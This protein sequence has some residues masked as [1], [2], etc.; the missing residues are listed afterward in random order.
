MRYQ[1]KKAHRA[2]RR[3]REVYRYF[4]PSN[5]AALN[6]TWLPFGNESNSAASLSASTPAFATEASTSAKVIHQTSSRHSSNTTLTSFAQL[7]ALGLNAERCLITIIDRETQY[8]LAEATR[9]IDVSDTSSFISPGDGLWLGTSTVKEAWSLC[10]ETIA[11]ETDDLSQRYPSFVVNNLKEDARFDSLPFVQ[12][13]P[14]FRFYA[15]TPL[16]TENGINIGCLFILDPVP[17][18]GISEVEKR[19]LGT[20]ASL[21]MDFL[22]VSRQASEGRR[23]SRLSRGLRHYVEGS[24]TFI[25]N[26]ESSTHTSLQSSSSR[27]VRFRSTSN[28]SSSKSSTKRSSRSGTGDTQSHEVPSDGRAPMTSSDAS[29]HVSDDDEEI[30]NAPPSNQKNSQQGNRWAFQRAANL[31][32]ESL[33]LRKGGGV[34]F[35][36]LGSN[37]II[38][39]ETGAFFSIETNIP[40]PLLA[41]STEDEPFEVS[42]GPKSLPAASDVDSAFLQQI[43]HRYPRGRLWSF[44]R[45]GTLTSSDEERLTGGSASEASDSGLKD[46]R[47]RTK[48]TET[49]M[50]NAFFP[51]A[52]QIMFVPLWDAAASQWHSGCFCWN[53]DETD[54]FSPAVDLN[55]VMGFASSVMTEVNRVDS[56]RADRRKGDFIGSVSH[57]LRSPLH[58]ILAAAEFL[59]DTC[60][61]GFQSSLIET[62]RSCGQT[63]LDT[64]NQVLDFTKI[65]SSDRKQKRLSRIAQD[66]SEPS[67]RR[68]SRLDPLVITDVSQLLEEVIESVCRGHSF[69]KKSAAKIDQTMRV[70]T[71]SSS[72]SGHSDKDPTD[73][74]EDVQVIIDIKNGDWMYLTQPGSLRRA[75]M[76]ILGN[77][78]KYT[79]HGKIV[80]RLEVD[81]QRLDIPRRQGLEDEV[82]ITVSDTGKGISKSF[83]REKLFKPFNQEDPLAVGTGLGLSI[84]RSLVRN[85]NGRIG[86]ESRPSEGTT[87]TLM[88]PLARLVGKDTSSVTPHSIP[89]SSELDLHGLRRLRHSHAHKRFAIWGLET[90]AMGQ[91]DIF[92]AAIREYMTMWFSMQLVPLSPNEEVDLILVKQ[93]NTSRIARQ[94]SPGYRGLVL[95]FCNDPAE[96]R[97]NENEVSEITY[98]LAFVWLPCGPR[99]LARAIL[100]ILDSSSEEDN[101]HS[102]TQGPSLAKIAPALSPNIQANF[103]Q[104]PD[105]GVLNPEKDAMHRTTESSLANGPAPFQTT[106]DT[107]SAIRPFPAAEAS[108]SDID[109]SQ[110]HQCAPR[111]LVVEDN[112]INLKLILT[113]LK[114]RDYHVLDA[115]TNGKM[116][117]N[118]AEN[119][120]IGYD[121]IFMDMSMPIMDGFEATRTIRCIEREKDGGKAA[122]IVAFTGLSSFEDE[123]KA[124]A[125]GVDMFLSKPVSFRDVAR[126]LD[127]WEIKRKDSSK[128]VRTAS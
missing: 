72:F 108:A 113:F 96:F 116:A 86:I 61:S 46:T 93:Y 103:T 80:V 2:D 57:E 115:A 17:R 45:D 124:F 51:K 33:E 44:H 83:L 16:R 126:L 120:C 4:Q 21:V 102:G 11:L 79:H 36:E 25:H 117:V 14:N 127:D 111:I 74:R 112:E 105:A 95:A 38:Q 118:L 85:M 60:L 65:M 94:L 49:S 71:Q 66:I 81:H 56:L 89:T 19:S 91:D 110:K 28:K 73:S 43:V 82:K 5:P 90:T 50:L 7:A 35:L 123:T 122:F 54:I 15:G 40:A 98:R 121:I 62:I 104:I 42:E 58:G 88:L 106:E 107:S 29:T 37:H 64:M 39:E 41:I 69:G 13:S 20:I 97:K 101:Y 55:A 1:K 77:A 30:S 23:S 18:L 67:T 48:A 31:L 53:T 32:R 12:G 119:N 84:V 128:E 8:N 92:W 99:K 70:A 125:A 109:N 24:S 3:S 6:S 47:Q 22:R 26:I 9:T 52:S 78:L 76:N 10:Q 63:L 68:V 75:V 27:S 59:E 34:V 100:E 87:V 114:K